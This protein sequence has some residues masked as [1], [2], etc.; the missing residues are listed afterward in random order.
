MKNKKFMRLLTALLSLAIILTVFSG[1]NKKEEI[2]T[3]TVPT[4]EQSLVYNMTSEPDSIDPCKSTSTTAGEIELQIFEGLTRIKDNNA[5][6]PGVAEKWDISTDG[7]KYTFHLRK[8]AKWSDGQIVTAKD[9]DYAWKRVLDPAMASE[10]ANQLFYVKNAKEYYEGKAKIEDIGIKVVDDNTLEVTLHSPIPYFLELCAFHTL[11]P[12][13]KDVVDKNPDAWFTDPAT[14]I[15]N[16]PFKM[17]KWVHNDSMEFAKSETYWDAK[18]INLT[19]MKWVMINDE[20]A[21]LAA[22]EGG[23]IDVAQTFPGSEAPRLIQE[24]KLILT[25]RLGTYYMKYNV[26]KKPL[27]DVRVRQAL[28]LAINRQ[29]LIDAATKTGEKP[30][31]AFVPPGIADSDTSKEFRTVGGDYIP[32]QDVEKA[33]ALLA[34]AGY[35]DGKGFPQLEYLYN[36]SET[37]RVIAEAIQ[38]MW[39]Q[40]LGIDIKLTNQEFKVY[41]DSQD[42][43][44]YD[45]SR[46][47]W[48]G[49]YMDPMT[50]IDMFVTN[51]GN[52]DTG[53][54]N[55][56]YDELVKTTKSEADQAKRMQYMHDAEKIL[57]DEMPVGPIYFYVN[58]NLIK[59]KITGIHVSLTGQLNFDHAKVTE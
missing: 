26:T 46:S 5:P 28:T 4:I 2:P 8:D 52:N 13:R 56:K 3:T 33:K 15:G 27:D 21:S 50:F 38:D 53:W 55:A 40:N 9:F 11:S 23:A 12:V 20:Q 30:G 37:H 22:W 58:K 39:K 10:Y 6:G 42:N 19:K 17:T 29:Q 59:T 25:P 36:T 32:N 41:L 35:P 51:D 54:S 45:I 7:L 47:G 18:N 34:E 44:K 49:D 31:L 14:Y 43:L 24:G 16:G 48:I 1:C 57:M